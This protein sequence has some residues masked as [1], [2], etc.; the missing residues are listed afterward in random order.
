MWISQLQRIIHVSYCVDSKVAIHSLTVPP[1]K[2][3][4]D[5]NGTLSPTGRGSA[6]KT[7]LPPVPNS[8][9]CSIISND[10]G[11]GASAGGEVKRGVRQGCRSAPVS[12][13]G[14]FVRQPA[15]N[16]GDGISRLPVQV[17]NSMSTETVLLLI[18]IRTYART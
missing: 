7:P 13:D 8:P 4:D 16:S 11:F 10:S 9:R 12:G 5:D 18:Y 1:Q 3:L 14:Q 17:I 6:L 2:G 15:S